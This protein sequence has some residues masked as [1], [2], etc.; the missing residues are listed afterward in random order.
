[1]GHKVSVVTQYGD[2]Q[3]HAANTSCRRA[4]LGFLAT[5][6]AHAQDV[7]DPADPIPVAVYSRNDE[8]SEGW[9][10][11]WVALTGAETI[12][13][14]A[15]DLD[16]DTSDVRAISVTIDLTT[17]DDAVTDTFE[18]VTSGMHEGDDT[19]SFWAFVHSAIAR[20]WHDGIYIP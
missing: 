14:L 17:D 20:R 13:M 16:T 6:L 10:L 15:Q 19:P 3:F 4:V 12:C 11:V 18:A 9:H 5:K 8:Q 1:M 7:G 2:S